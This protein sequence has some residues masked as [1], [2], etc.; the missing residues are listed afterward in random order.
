MSLTFVIGDATQPK[1]NENEIVYI[2]HI[3]NDIGAW[4]KGFV[5]A[6]S[7]KWNLPKQEYKKLKNYNCGD[8]GYVQVESNIV[9]C[10]MIAQVGIYKKNGV[11][12]V[13]YDAL[14]KCLENV[15]DKILQQDKKI[16]IAMPRIGCGL[17]G[18]KWYI[19]EKIINDTL[20]KNN[21]SVI[22]YDLPNP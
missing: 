3:C 13:R 17:A 9:V 22:V 19:V 1:I 21:I 7:K 16:F 11:A 18:G 14:K 5:M 2:C 8:V 10:N 4:G 6:L 20:I 15:V 12:P